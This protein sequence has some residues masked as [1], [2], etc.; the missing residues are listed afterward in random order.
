MPRPTGIAGRIVLETLAEFPKAGSRTIA[1]ILL[2][3]HP[4]VF[5]TFESARTRVRYYRGN[6]GMQK[7]QGLSNKTFLRSLPVKPAAGFPRLPEG[8]TSFEHW[9]TV[10][11][12]GPDKALILSDIHIPYHDRQAIE[13]SCDQLPNATL[14]LLNG[15]IMDCFEASKYMPDPRKCDFVGAL[16]KG[17]QFIRWIRKRYPRAKI[18]FKKANHEERLERYFITRAPAVLGI[19]DFEIERLLR[20]EEHRIECVGDRRPIKLG[21]LNIIHGH[22]YKT[23]FTNPVNPARGL[24]LKGKAQA[25]CGHYHQW[26]NHSERD[27]DGNVISTWS[28]GC[29]CDLHPEYLVLN[30]WSHGAATVKVDAEGNFVVNN[31]KIINGKVY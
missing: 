13:I 7:R 3:R 15:D 31:F 27:L 4:K 18:I 20:L 23:P 24:F 22:E 6:Q 25:M 5:G 30:N 12:P 2:K 21:K 28:T 16:D 10:V 26:S 19:S 1:E 29:L 14:V 9:S 8:I 11:I 17:R